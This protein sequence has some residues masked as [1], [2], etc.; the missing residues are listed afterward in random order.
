MK[1]KKQGQFKKGHTVFGNGIQKAIEYNRIHGVWNSGIKIDR[2]KYPNMGHNKPH[3][4]ETKTKE[5]ETITRLFKEGKIRTRRGQHNSLE[6]IRKSSETKKRLFSEGKLI[7]NRLGKKN[8]KESIIKGIETRMKNGGYP[9]GES[10]YN[11][12]KHPVAWNRGLKGTH[13]SPNTE[14]KK[15]DPELSRRSKEVRSKQIFPKQDT[16]IEVKIQNYLKELKIGFFT[17]YYCKEIEHSYQV[18][19]FIPVQKSNT[20]FIKQPIIIECDGDYWHNYPVGRDIDHIRT[21][22]LIEK[23]FKVLRLWERDIRKIELNELKENLI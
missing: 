7:P 21:S 3:T 18:D 23:G 5:S 15:G 12:G 16:S 20:F 4:E 22:E 14:F 9:T 6:H 11:Y 2:N 13:F 1:K 10:N 19:I 8:S 17:H